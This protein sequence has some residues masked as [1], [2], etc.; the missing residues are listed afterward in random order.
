VL[1]LIEVGNLI[2]YMFGRN[3]EY[4]ILFIYNFYKLIETY[5]FLL[6]M[7]SFF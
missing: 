2:L 4:I 3:F 5:T 7:Y 6:I 1:R